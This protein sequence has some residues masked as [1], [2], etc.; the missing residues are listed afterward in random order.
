MCHKE[1]ELPKT[2]KSEIYRRG[3]FFLTTHEY[4]SAHRSRYCNDSNYTRR[5]GWAEKNIA[6]YRHWINDIYGEELREK[7]GGGGGGG[8][9]LILW[10][11]KKSRPGRRDVWKREMKVWITNGWERKRQWRSVTPRRGAVAPLTVSAR[12]AIMNWE[13]E[14]SLEIKKKKRGGTGGRNQA[15]KRRRMTKRANPSGGSRSAQHP[16][17]LPTAPESFLLPTKRT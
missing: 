10:G 4:Y 17:P 3:F 16:P 9:E 1:E 11:K 14:K 5:P 6:G 7:T 13:G 2:Q 12:P 8:S 15:I